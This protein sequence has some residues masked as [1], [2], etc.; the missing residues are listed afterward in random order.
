MEWLLMEWVWRV[1]VL[2]VLIGIGAD[3]AVI[4]RYMR[5]R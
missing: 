1:V 4:R 3:V 2:V 5:R